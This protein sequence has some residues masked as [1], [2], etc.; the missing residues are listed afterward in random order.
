MAQLAI[1]EA[2]NRFM[3]QPARQK[4]QSNIYMDDLMLGAHH[5]ENLDSIVQEVDMG[6]KKAYLTYARIY[7]QRLF[8]MF[9]SIHTFNFALILGFLLPYFLVK[10]EQFLAQGKVQ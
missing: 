6:L 5:G 7:D 1:S 10:N 3:K 9:P 2:A 8:T 4:C